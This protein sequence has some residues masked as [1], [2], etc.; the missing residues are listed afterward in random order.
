MMNVIS[1]WHDDA[2]VVMLNYF[3]LELGVLSK[4]QQSRTDLFQ[5]F[6]YDII[7]EIGLK[8]INMFG[9]IAKKDAYSD[10]VGNSN[11]KEEN[12]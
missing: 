7:D 12:S 8:L 6:D 11:P 1:N 9:I 10:D 3:M 5:D 4:S 2:K